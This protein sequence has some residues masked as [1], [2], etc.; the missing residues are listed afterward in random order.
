MFSPPQSQVNAEEVAE[1][2]ATVGPL[3]AGGQ[4]MAIGLRVDD[5]MRDLR[6]TGSRLRG[7][8]Y[9]NCQWSRAVG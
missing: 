5:R 9:R 7:L 4:A 6:G 8:A 1:T 2:Q 3:A